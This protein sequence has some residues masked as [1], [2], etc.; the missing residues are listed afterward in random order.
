MHD[1]HPYVAWLV[2]PLFAFAKAGVSFAGLSV[3]QAMAPLVLGIALGLF[4]GK[5]IG[6]FGAA[7][8]ASALKIGHRPTGA[9]WLELYGVSLLCG[10]GFTMSLFVGLLAFPGA[11][12]SPAQVEVKLGVLGGSFLSAVAG[13]AVLAVAARRRKVLAGACADTHTG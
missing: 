7:W 2:L 10:V 8:L 9:T 13:A 3:E 11:I 4:L 1:L 5:Q 12:D 6:V